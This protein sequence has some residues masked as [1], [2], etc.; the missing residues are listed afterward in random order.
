MEQIFLKKNTEQLNESWNPVIGELALN[1]LSK[2]GIKDSEK[3]TT[4][5]EACDI[6]KSCGNPVSSLA[7]DTGLVVGYVQSGKTLSFTTV[8]AI[9]VENG[10]NCVIVIAGSTTKLV[11]QTSTRLLKDLYCETSTLKFKSYQNPKFE[12][13]N[14]MVNDLGDNVFGD[15]N[16]LLIT[17]MKNTS[18]L[19]NL[20][21]LFSSKKIKEQD[22]K[23]LIIDDEADQ[24]SLNTKAKKNDP[25]DVST[26]YR[27]LRELRAELKNHTY[28]QYTATPQAPLFISLMDILSPSFVKVITPGGAY[29]GGKTFF[30]RNKTSNYPYLEDIGIEE[31]YTKKNPLNKVPKSLEDA[32]MNFVLTVSIG[33]LKGEKPEKNNRTMMIH[34]SVLKVV[35]EKYYTWTKS[36]INRWKDELQLNDSDIDKIHLLRR[37]EEIHNLFPVT[38]VNLYSFTTIKEILHATLDITKIQIANS[39]A[40]KEIDWKRNYALILVGGAILDR[41]FTIEGL[42]VT[43]MPRSI[44]GGN[45]DTIQQRCRF[46]GYKKSYLDLCK[47]YLPRL[48]KRAYIEYVLH[49]EDMRNKLSEFSGR[50]E[51]L[52]SFK[53][54]FI[55]SPLLNITRKNVISEDVIKYG[56]KGWKTIDIV[57]ENQLELSSV[58]SDFI[59]DLHFETCKFSGLNEMQTHDSTTVN[60]QFLIEGLLSK[61]SYKEPKNSLIISYVISMLQIL[62]DEKIKQVYIVNMSQGEERIR[63]IKNRKISNLMQGSN[64]NTFYNGD[65]N[66]KEENMFTFQ[67]HKI[68]AKEEGTTFYTLAIHIPEK[69]SQSIITLS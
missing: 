22:L 60:T 41:G 13:V 46:F 62:I 52:S 55:L 17:V 24:A 58:I 2:N 49:E 21:T 20:K 27:L 68:K 53:R 67:V 61:I 57:D 3:T 42:N 33:I 44:G 69:L 30:K 39:D 6:L 48:S 63:T 15:K 32:L 35:H 25:N 23:I 51:P 19:R 45:A 16:V 36:I 10:F 43:Y 40:E 37:F 18:H 47:I 5:D 54:E 4:L 34:P 28:L 7:G 14:D 1:V 12:E 65:R 11:D 66:V 8:S 59:S 50:N 31:I 64:K 56:L 9:A 29:T 26:T 38:I